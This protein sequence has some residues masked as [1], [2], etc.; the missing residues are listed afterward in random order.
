MHPLALPSKI[1]EEGIKKSTTGPT[2]V[3]GNCTDI[4]K[5]RDF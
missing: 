1:N 2:R 5:T 3:K 4:T